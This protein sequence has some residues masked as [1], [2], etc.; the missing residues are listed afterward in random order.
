MKTKRNNVDEFLWFVDGERK[1]L[2]VSF[3]RYQQEVKLVISLWRIMRE[4]LIKEVRPKVILF[5]TYKSQVDKTIF[6]AILSAMRLHSIQC[7][8]MLRYAV[9]SM[10]LS[11]Y[12]LFNPENA[13]AILSKKDATGKHDIKNTEKIA[14]ASYKW[15]ASFDPKLSDRFKEVK[16][17]VANPMGAHV[18]FASTSYNTQI[19]KKVWLNV[20]DEPSDKMQRFRFWL[21]ADT[22]CFYINFLLTNAEKNGVLLNKEVIE[23]IK[24]LFKRT[25]ELK[26]SLKT[27]W[28]Y[29]I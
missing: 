19:K 12:I 14:D 21:I 25:E 5:M 8:S 27:I 9:D 23:E 20:F 18:S 17:V 11:A 26:S 10:S 6:L 15:L 7:F 24:P 29:R 1:H 4:P 16:A 28:N 2:E 22:M 13:I 3:N